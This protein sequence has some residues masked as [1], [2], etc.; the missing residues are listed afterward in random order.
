MKLNFLLGTKAQFIKTIPVINESIARGYEVCLYDLNQH[1]KTSKHLLKK[2]DN[3]Y[4]YVSLT[5]NQNDLGTY[6]DLIKWFFYLIFNFLIIKKLKFKNEVCIVHGDTLSTFLGAFITKKGRGTL[7]L[8]EAGHPVPGVLHHFPESIIRYITAKISKILIANGKDQ[9]K[10]LKKWKVKGKIIEISTNS[11]LDSFKKVSLHDQKVS[12][13][14][15]VAVHRNENLNSR[16]KMEMLAKT[17][18]DA[19]A[20]YD[21][22]WYLHIPT[23]NKLKK[24]KLID[25]LTNANIN[26][27]ELI[28]YDKFINELHNSV[29]VI[30]D[31]GSLVEECQI[32][33]VP[34]L[35][36]RNEHLDQNHLFEIGKNLYLSNYNQNDIKFFLSNYKNFDR[37]INVDFKTS[38]SKEIVNALNDW[39]SFKVVYVLGTKA[40]FIK[41]KHILE[42][43]ISKNI[44]VV[45]LDTGQHREF[46]TKELGES[47]LIYEYINISKNKTN[48]SSISAMIVWFLKIVFSL[49][50]KHSL[51][52]VSFC[53]VHG[54]TVS[55]LV[56][57]LYAKYNRYKTVHLESGY[58]SFNLL[59]PF[60]EEIIRNIVTKYSDFLIVD[61]K[62][63]L[64]NVAKYKDKKKILEIP[65]NTII[66]SLIEFNLKDPVDLKNNLTVTVHRTE[67][68]YNKKKILLLIELLK[69]I[70][71]KYSF[72][73]INWFCHDVTL[74]ALRKYNLEELV[75]K[76]NIELK[77]LTTH[78]TFV[79]ELR[80]S[81]LVITDGGSIAE[82][83]Y[84][85]GLN[86][87]IWRDVVENEEYLNEHVILS[88]YNFETIFMFLNVMKDRRNMFKNFDSPSEKL[89]DQLVEYL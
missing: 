32:L 58:K 64:N 56:G 79:K 7:V 10:Q 36:W 21:I 14:V 13:K 70:Q 49:K 3:G 25:K 77:N 71:I 16:K 57:L 41:C 85:L 53:M 78:N 46:T 9:V 48:V 15:T 19:S 5:K 23:R 29:F 72:D 28:E 75:K 87:I 44:K 51:G 82:E 74:N 89:V 6:Y 8:L 2:I 81:K 76:N 45:I 62:T 37:K 67:N 12:N 34:T 88:K 55:T 80:S 61:G 4:S 52:N 43:L 66:D 20:D 11:I 73:K 84:I 65:R 42:N 39:L 30:T 63:Q 40:Q 22:T 24:Y 18:I 69:D 83:C 26:L 38:P 1:A 68:I 50:N 35:V 86:T 47:G 59:K 17:I 27:K 60:P 33:G 54:D 31:G